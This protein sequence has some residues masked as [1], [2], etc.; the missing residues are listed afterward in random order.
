[1]RA[2]GRDADGILYL[3]SR[4]RVW[5]FPDPAPFRALHDLALD[6]TPY[7]SHTLYGT[8]APA[9]VIR[10]RV[11]AAHRIVVLRDP[12]GQPV[13]RTPQ[14]IAKRQVLAR[15][16]VSCGTRRVHGAR[17]SVYARPGRC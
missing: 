17:V 3:P 6:R 11:L 12:A 8:E 16:F 10:A 4:R 7:A 2:E 15:Y 1:M 9:P 5:S 13:D 14:E